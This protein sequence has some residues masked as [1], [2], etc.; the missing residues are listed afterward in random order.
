MYRVGDAGGSDEQR[1]V[2]NR[3]SR[4]VRR[5]IQILQCLESLEK[6]SKRTKNRTL[7]NVN[8]VDRSRKDTQNRL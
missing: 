4:M 8:L 1:H 7:R 3:F 5:A 6:A 2:E